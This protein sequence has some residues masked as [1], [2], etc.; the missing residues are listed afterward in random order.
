M[1]SALALAG[2]IAAAPL[3]TDYPALDLPT[4]LMLRFYTVPTD[5]SCD[6]GACKAPA[7]DQPVQADELAAFRAQK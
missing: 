6:D 5:R 4:L 3:A 2:G 7:N 1:T